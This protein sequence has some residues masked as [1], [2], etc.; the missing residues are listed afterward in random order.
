MDL[1]DPIPESTEWGWWEL[2]VLPPLWMITLVWDEEVVLGVWKFESML[3]MGEEVE[4]VI[5]SDRSEVSK[6]S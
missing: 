2:V 5:R 3:E 1:G 4:S 6:W